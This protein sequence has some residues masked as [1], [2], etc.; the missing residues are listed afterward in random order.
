MRFVAPPA[1]HP[2]S[3]ATMTDRFFSSPLAGDCAAEDCASKECSSVTTAAPSPITAPKRLTDP[4]RTSPTA[5]TPRML[6]SSGNRA[7]ARLLVRDLP[8]ARS[9]PVCTNPFASRATPKSR[10]QSRRRAHCL[11]QEKRRHRKG[12]L[13]R[14]ERRV[15]GRLRR[16]LWVA[17]PIFAAATQCR[18]TLLTLSEALPATVLHHDEWYQDL[19]VKSGVEDIIASNVFEDA[20]STVILGIHRQAGKGPFAPACLA[21]LT[22]LPQPLRMAARFDIQLRRA[23]WKASIASQ[24]LDQLASG[25]IIA[26]ED[27]RVIE[28]YQVAERILRRSDDQRRETDRASRRRRCEAPR[29]VAASAA[30]AQTRAPIRGMFIGRVGNR[31]AY[32][33]TIARISESLALP[34]LPFGDDP[35]VRPRCRPPGDPRLHRAVWPVAGRKPTGRG[36]YRGKEASPYCRRLRGPD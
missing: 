28:T 27:G 21:A 26:D 24:A 16:S 25:M 35:P 4:D 19:V 32:S 1:L 3:A 12:E 5:K 23:D 36:A 18:W 8:G 2:S 10:N 33:L 11:Q 15:E 30:N 6:D 31:A 9:K 20:S 7:S 29:L 14:S 17:R 34:G 13:R 22:V